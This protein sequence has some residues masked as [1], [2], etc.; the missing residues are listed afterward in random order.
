MDLMADNKSTWGF[1]QKQIDI[2]KRTEAFI[3]VLFCKIALRTRFV[4]IR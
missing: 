2:A 1:F 4:V 3:L